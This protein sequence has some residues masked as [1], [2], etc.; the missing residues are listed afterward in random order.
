MIGA[1]PFLAPT[2]APLIWT[3]YK[4][5]SILPSL[6][7]VDIYDHFTN[8]MLRSLVETNLNKSCT[9]HAFSLCLPYYSMLYLAPIFLSPTRA[10]DS[11]KLNFKICAHHF[12]NF[13]MLF[14]I[15]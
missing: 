13:A 15:V 6:L 11:Q 14:L 5:Q 7:C 2:K 9:T 8:S 12:Y 1:S 3:T 10:K 4:I